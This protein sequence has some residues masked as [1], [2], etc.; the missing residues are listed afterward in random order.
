MLLFS[1][2]II[3]LSWVFEKVE[4]NLVTRFIA[5]SILSHSLG[6]FYDRRLLIERF[7]LKTVHHSFLE[8]LKH[9]SY[10]RTAMRIIDRKFSDRAAWA[11][12][13][14]ESYRLLAKINP[15]FS[16]QL[17]VILLKMDRLIE[18]SKSG[19]NFTLTGIFWIFSSTGTGRSVSA[20]STREW[21]IAA[22]GPERF[23]REVEASWFPQ[24]HPFHRIA[25]SICPPRARG[26]RYESSYEMILLLLDL[27]AS[28]RPFY[29]LGINTWHFGPAVSESL[30]FGPG[31]GRCSFDNR[32]FLQEKRNEQVKIHQR[33][34]A[35]P[36]VFEEIYNVLRSCKRLS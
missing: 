22:R 18:G 16:L 27:V 23:C 24:F 2:R 4:L 34:S 26:L 13:S 9:L 35:I 8:I 28:F 3:E 36:I 14:R 7:S 33:V 1:S 31:Y 32:I 30:R 21:Q 12:L 5:F 17:Q 19:W 6:Q 15:T 29:G 20:V 25:H 11:K 10:F